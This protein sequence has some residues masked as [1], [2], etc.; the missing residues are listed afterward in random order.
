MSAVHRRT[1]RRTEHDPVRTLSKTVAVLSGLTLLAAAI[2]PVATAA[3]G[4]AGAA[5]SAAVLAQGNAQT[6]RAAK[7]S[8]AT[9]G[10]QLLRRTQL[11]SSPG[12]PVVATLA[13]R[14]EYG[15]PR[16]LAV[17]AR[18]GRWLGV[19]SDAMPNS[20][21]GWIPVTRARL[22]QERYGIDVDRS[23]RLLTI[24]RD[25][26]VVRRLRIAVGASS[27]ATPT[28]RY[29]VTDSVLYGSGPYG[30]CALPITGH[31]SALPADRNRLA[32]HGTIAEDSIGS[33]ASAG[34]LRAHDA[35]MR[36]LVTRISAGTQV[37]IRA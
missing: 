2:T 14:T 28:G 10:A 27:T 31:Q 24:R 37:R 5:G 19:L 18:R 12:G 3:T 8:N 16:V 17:V 35:D 26:R 4:T 34:C 33:A 23:E 29:A 21:A 9:L 32:I 30:C 1:R 15:S 36:W 11:R 6:V 25:G 22:R 7:A 20:R 13:T